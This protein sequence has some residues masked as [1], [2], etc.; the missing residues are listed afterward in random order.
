MPKRPCIAVRRVRVLPLSPPASP[1]L[2]RTHLSVRAPHRRLLQ[3]HRLGLRL[4][5]LDLLL[6]VRERARELQQHLLQPVLL[7]QGGCGRAGGQALLPAVDGPFKHG[8]WAMVLVQP[9]RPAERAAPAGACCTGALRAA[10]HAPSMFLFTC[11]ASPSTFRSTAMIC[12]G[13]SGQQCAVGRWLRA[14]APRLPTI[15]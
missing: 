3:L 12:A 10:H 8:G 11:P 14:G 5:A 9:A 6:R 4:H 15:W 1:A 13:A 7:L 2:P